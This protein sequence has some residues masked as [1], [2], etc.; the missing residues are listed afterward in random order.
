[1]K[2]KRPT[3]SPNFN[4]LGQLLDFEKKIKV[5][6]GSDGR[7]KP[8]PLSTPGGGTPAHLTE[9]EPLAQLDALEGPAP[10]EVEPCVLAD[11]P[12]DL[13]EAVGGLQLDEDNARLKRSFSLDIRSYGEHSGSAPAAP[14]PHGGP[15]ED[16]YKAPPF[17]E[18]GGK[19]CQF[20]PVEEVSEQSTPEQSPDK[21][22]AGG[23]ERAAPPSSFSKPPPAAPP[24]PRQLQRSGSMEESGASFLWGV[25]C[26]QQ[27]V[28]RPRS[29]A[30]LKGWHSDILLGPVAVS[31]SS[32]AAGW[33]LSESPHFFSA[34]TVLGGG[35]LSPYGCGPGL[36]AVRR[37]GRQRA[38]D[39]GDSRRSWHEESSFE[40]QLK[41]R[42]CQMELGDGGGPAREDGAATR[43]G[44]GFSSSMEVIQVS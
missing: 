27:H 42:S 5:P 3:I 16:F 4:F 13:V 38:A 34:S 31:T 14:G 37:R 39:R 44:S 22:A 2:D 1:M 41:R 28:A 21:E 36:E 15:A 8:L 9:V 40:K 30:A 25:S 29:G 7:L 32:L 26:S 12:L 43:R 6:V 33:F 10:L 35:G 19:L 24:C 23:V 17:K 20:S 11:A 18:S